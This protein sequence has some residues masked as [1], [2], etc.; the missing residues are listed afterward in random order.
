MVRIWQATQDPLLGTRDPACD[1]ELSVNGFGLT[2]GVHGP[3]ANLNPPIQQTRQHARVLSART[4]T[5]I[6]HVCPKLVCHMSAEATDQCMLSLTHLA[7]D[8][9]KVNATNHC[10]DV[11]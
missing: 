1:S 7:Q 3:A 11:Q 4:Y 2:D 5:R 10:I 9:T 8:Q 6:Q